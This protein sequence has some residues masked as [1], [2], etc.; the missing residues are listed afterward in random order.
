[1]ICREL[2]RFGK[3]PRIRYM[4]EYTWPDMFVICFDWRI[5][6]TIWRTV[7]SNGTLIFIW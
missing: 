3:A 5:V 4:V 1:M 2:D 7:E 6:L